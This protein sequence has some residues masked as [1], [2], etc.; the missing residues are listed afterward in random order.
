MQCS[1]S[2]VVYKFGKSKWGPRG[3]NRSELVCFHG[4]IQMSAM[5]RGHIANEMHL[6]TRYICAYGYRVRFESTPKTW[7][8]LFSSIYSQNVVGKKILGEFKPSNKS[9][10]AKRPPNLKPYISSPCQATWCGLWVC[11]EAFRIKEQRGKY[12]RLTEFINTNPSGNANPH[13]EESRCTS[14]KE[15]LSQRL[16]WRD[17]LR[18][19]KICMFP[20]PCGRIEMEKAGGQAKHLFKPLG[21]VRH[22]TSSPKS[23][24]WA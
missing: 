24:P 3:S 16:V 8:V 11:S 21:H 7:Q 4:K 19:G 6:A 1:P 9:D 17:D 20:K 14:T 2:D 13:L 12:S 5:D 15:S 23:S 18:D 10:H 22:K